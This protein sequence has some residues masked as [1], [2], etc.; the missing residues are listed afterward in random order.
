M[1]DKCL[2]LVIASIGVVA[3]IGFFISKKPGFGRYSLSILLLIVVLIISAILNVANK[4]NSENLINIL[5]AVIGFASGLFR[6][7]NESASAGVLNNEKGG[8]DV[9]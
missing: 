8:N 2:I 4:I 5:F 9:K 3:L 7:G 6:G 1:N